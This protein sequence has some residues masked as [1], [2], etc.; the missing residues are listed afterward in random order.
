MI[1]AIAIDDEPIALDVIKNH[2]EKTDFI[3]IVA[4]FS[5]ATEAYSFLQRNTD[6][7]LVFMDI[8][9]PDVSG[10]ELAEHIK[11]PTQIIFTTAY[12]E[13]AVKGFE[14]AAT[15]YLLKP[16]DLDRFFK[17]CK[18]AETRLNAG[19]STIEK[20]SNL[21]VKDGY[22][23]VKI[24][25]DDLLY[26][27]ANDNYVSLFEAQKRTLT[28]MTLSKLLTKLPKE[29]FIQ[30]HKSFVV[31]L[32]KINRV[33]KQHLIVAGVKIPVSNSFKEA[34]LQVLNK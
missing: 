6:I 21:F 12:P 16:I 34:V 9:M 25:F 26:A 2:A 32:S 19:I 30:V 22:N 8:N 1:K 10:L 7:R 13:H 31:S 33:E 24:N 28:R 23:W 4:F 20:E 14:L 11:P 3:N 18:L 15:D 17:A 27:E 5:S 29:K